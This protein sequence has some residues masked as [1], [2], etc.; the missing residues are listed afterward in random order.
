MLRGRA[1]RTTPSQ[2]HSE[3][4][5]VPDWVSDGQQQGPT[6]FLYFPGCRRTDILFD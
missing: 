4:S 2:Q 5:T 1:L 6:V 3:T